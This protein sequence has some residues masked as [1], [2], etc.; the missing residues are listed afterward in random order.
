ME[1]FKNY[2]DFENRILSLYPYAEN[3]QISKSQMNKKILQSFENDDIL[4]VTNI[5]SSV[6]RHSLNND[7]I[8]TS[9]Y[10]SI[11]RKNI[12]YLNIENDKIVAFCILGRENKQIFQQNI[13]FQGLKQYCIENQKSIPKLI[14]IFQKSSYSV[15]SILILCSSKK[16]KGKQ[17]I[18]EIPSSIIQNAF[19]LSVDSPLKPLKKYYQ[20]LGFIYEKDLYSWSGTI[21][22]VI[23]K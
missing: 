22:K 3:A 8:L 9:L 18:D 15:Y 19:I 4:K 6:C 23:E 1:I 13:D 5:L 12:Y 20:S 10:S 2:N 21:Y 14:Q 11:S 16:G 7:F 17:L